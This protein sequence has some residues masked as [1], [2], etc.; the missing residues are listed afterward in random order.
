MAC[1]VDG[2]ERPIYVAHA[3]MCSLHYNRQRVTGSVEGSGLKPRG[4]LADRLWVK[5]D[6]RSPNECWPF[7]GKARKTGGYG[8]IRRGGRGSQM[9]G[10][11]RAAYE[12]THGPIGD[13]SQV[14]MHS[15]DNPICC[16]PAHLSLG[17]TKDN[18]ADM[19]EKGRQNPVVGDA[20]HGA[21]ITDA[22][23]LVIRAG[24]HTIA[25]LSR[26]FGLTRSTIRAIRDGR[27]WKH[28]RMGDRWALIAEAN[29]NNPQRLTESDVRAIRASSKTA[30]ELAA[31]YGVSDV[32][33][34]NV[35]TRKTWKHVT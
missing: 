16:N 9:I 15:C 10:A 27:T 20:H 11:H 4:S 1:L 28:V 6:V 5:V 32:S 34:Y 22:D 17:T 31:K 30:K 29:A 7:I 19:Y 14:V 8:V 18:V 26:R 35:L 21:K 13:S 3:G 12:V 24:G 25:D 2:C 33:I 23:V